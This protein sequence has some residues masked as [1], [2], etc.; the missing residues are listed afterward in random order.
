MTREEKVK[1]LLQNEENARE[2]FVEDADQTLA[3]LAAH[4]VE[5]NKEELGELASGILC[6]MGKEEEL[7]EG[8]LENVAGGFAAKKLLDAALKDVVKAVGVGYIKGR[9][10]KKS[11]SLK[12]MAYVDSA[13]TIVGKGW[14]SIG[15]TIGWYLS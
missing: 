15:Y 14:R 12:G 2:I 13:N 11:K 5:M 9:K 10:D 8:E 6:G 1:E 7:S 4:G 3:N